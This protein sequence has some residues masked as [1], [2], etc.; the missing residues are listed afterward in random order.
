[1]KGKVYLVG[2]GPGDP[3]L[4][5]VKGLEAIRQAD[6]I[7]YD[8]LASPRLLQQAKVTAQQIYVGKQP[9]QHTMTQEEINELLVK[10]ARQG[11]IVTRLKGGD[12]FVFGRGGEEAQTLVLAGI[13]FEVVPGITSAIAVPA[14]AGIPVTHRDHSASF[15]VVTGHERFE[16]QDSSHHWKTLA[17]ATETL[18]FLMGV[19]NLPLI[20]EQLVKYGRDP[21]TPVALIRWG[22]RPEQRTL[23]GTLSNIVHRVR[24]QGFTSPAVIVVGEVVQLHNELNWF[25]KMPLFGK[26]ILVTRAREQSSVLAQQIAT[27]GGEPLE[28]PV[29]RTVA[30]NDQQAFDQ[31]LEQLANFD[32]FIFTSAN[33]VRY[34]LQLLRDRQIDIRQL[35]P[36]KIA[37]VGSKTA[38]ILA[39]HGLL[40]DV[41]PEKH[42]AE[43]LVEA[44]R[45]QVKSGEQ[46]LL[47]RARVARAVLIDE[48][49][50]MGAKVSDVPVYE[51]QLQA[52]DATRVLDLLRK[53]RIDVVTFTS[54][55]TVHHLMQTL[56]EHE[57]EIQPLLSATQLACIG[58]VTAKTLSE[59][60][61]Q[62]DVVA[63]PYT[64]EG[65]LAAI[66]DKG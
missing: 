34:F 50:S 11:Q 54:S 56:R 14:Y 43:A 17:T 64:I 62:P 57:P 30:S 66:I 41:I 13:P 55:S 42:R 1:M 52:G 47:P 37:A 20:C 19:K 31:V 9:N 24:E 61:L 2:A 8:R 45:S 48:L 6:V 3:G 38:Q 21:Q 26:R 29:I 33:G 7:V 35:P 27:L 5:T 16:K 12:P 53:G 4:I 36:A 39:E 28:F 65:L 46:I 58:P 25:E 40:V 60:G 44:L 23:M 59:Y 22:T 63:D 49:R 32:W 18:I 10:H 15:A 51:T